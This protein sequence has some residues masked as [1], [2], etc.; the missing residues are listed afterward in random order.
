MKS[1]FLGGTT[2]TK[3]NRW[4]SEDQYNTFHKGAQ[5]CFIDALAYIQEKFLTTNEVICNSVW[6][7]V[8]KRH[9]TSWNN[10]EYFLKNLHV[11][12]L[13]KK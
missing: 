4:L 1:I 11:F 13:R 6:I 9:E 10:V 7:D 8:V 12:H 5:C 3:L 2:K